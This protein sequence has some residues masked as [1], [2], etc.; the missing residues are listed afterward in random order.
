MRRVGSTTELSTT[1]SR[2][3][4]TV[5]ALLA[6]A[7]LVSVMLA[8]RADRTQ[9]PDT[10]ITGVVLVAEGVMVSC[11]TGNGTG[12]VS[13]GECA[14]AVIRVSTSS[15]PSRIPVGSTR[16]VRDGAPWTVDEQYTG[17]V[18]TSRDAVIFV[19]I[20]WA[21]ALA[22]ILTAGALTTGQRKEPQP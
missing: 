22:T 3:G 20:A 11:P 9:P 5:V 7:V 19:Y 17:R 10:E 18:P 4:W 6:F 16:T 14:A 8:V 21:L 13:D 1:R 12:V 15:D 2:V